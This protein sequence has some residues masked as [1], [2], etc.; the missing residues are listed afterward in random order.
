[1]TS[2]TREIPSLPVSFPFVITSSEDRWAG[3]SSR[4]EPLD[5]SNLEEYRLRQNTPRIST[6]PI[7][8]WRRG[9]FS[10][11]RTA[12]GQ[13][14]PIYDPSTTRPNPN[15]QGQIRDLFPGNIVPTSRFDPI[16]RE[17]SRFLAGAE[18][19]T[20]QRFHS[21]PELRRSRAHPYRLDPVKRP[22]RPPVL[23]NQLNVLP[24]YP[25]PPSDCGQLDLH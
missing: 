16:T 2:S 15:G 13:L 12:Q 3:R 4:T 9:D 5:S 7:D 17:N 10:N 11:F 14:I 19:H 25:R 8:E 21:E 20:D 1:M 22:C 18:S 23:R 6:V 24:I